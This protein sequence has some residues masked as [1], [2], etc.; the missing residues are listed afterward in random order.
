MG[1]LFPMSE[2]PLYRSMSRSAETS[3]ALKE[4]AQ[5]LLSRDLAR[6]DENCP[7]GSL[8]SPQRALPTG[9]KVESG[10][11]QSKSGTSVNLGNGG[12]LGRFIVSTNLYR[13]MLCND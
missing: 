11:S 5:G 9:T 6:V 12:A 2:V 1:E 10:T 7:F 4:G 8:R 3:T 13:I